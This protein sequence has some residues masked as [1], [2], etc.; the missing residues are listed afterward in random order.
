MCDLSGTT[1][2]GLSIPFI[3][4]FYAFKNILTGLI[5]CTFTTM[6]RG[7]VVDIPFY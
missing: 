5:G 4:R 6:K 7:H 3:N 2:Q 1:Q